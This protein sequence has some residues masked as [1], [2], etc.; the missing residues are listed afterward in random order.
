MQ[1]GWPENEFARLEALNAYGILD[2]AAEKSYDDITCLAADICGTPIALI[3]LVD[4]TRQWFKSR[5]GLAAAQIPREHA[6]CAHAITDPNN[7]LVVED[8]SNDP[9]FASNPWVT[10]APAF[11]F[12][13]GAPIVTANGEV[14]G[15]VCVID[16]QPRQ[17]DAHALDSL[18]CLARQV[19]AQLEL[20]KSLTTLE[21]YQSILTQINAKLA[22]QNVID[23]LTQLHNRR[24]F[25]E[26][27]KAEWERTFRYSTPLSLLMIDIDHFKSFNDEFGY[28]AGDQVL[29]R[30][31]YVLSGTARLCDMVARYG[32]E[33]F[34][35]ILPGT[36]S[37]G[38]LQIAER[39]RS[40]IEAETGLQR[41]VTVSIGV[42]NYTNQP[43]TAAILKQVDQ[44][45]CQAKDQMGNCVVRAS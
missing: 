12:Y 37:A 18:H 43:D 14:L 42:A 2:T 28:P 30:V 27:L 35:V 45:L 8:A 6:F 36:D 3:S 5:I 26:T 4:E 33:R 38:A 17:L 16:Q 13:A 21:Y 29:R 23:E 10:D 34:A 20:R 40:K 9:R 44:A 25:Q 1:A 41:G 11:R 32:G 22:L 15:T 19:M 31:A 39:I 7:L 24:A